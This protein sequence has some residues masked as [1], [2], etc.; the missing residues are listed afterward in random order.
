[1][2]EIRSCWDAT[3]TC[4][5]LASLVATLL[6]LP[7]GVEAVR[8]E[9]EEPVAISADEAS[10]P[11]G[12]VPAVAEGEIEQAPRAM[13]PRAED[14]PGVIVLNTRGYNYG[15]ARPTAR[16]QVAPPAAVP[17]AAEDE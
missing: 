3:R 9:D 11:L 2:L 15:P 5:G 12:F 16:P 17:P 10:A 13:D 14:A 7:I 6:L 4:L 1:M 8:A